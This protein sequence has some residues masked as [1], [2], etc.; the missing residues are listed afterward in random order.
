[1]ESNALLNLRQADWHSRLGLSQKILTAFG[2]LCL[3]WV[4]LLPASP[5]LLKTPGI[6][7]GI[8]LYMGK[9]I[10][11]G[12]IPYRDLWDSNAP[13]VYFFNAIGLFF[14]RDNFWG[15]WVIQVFALWVTALIV[16]ALLKK[17]FGL[18]PA[19][20]I[21]AAVLFGYVYLYDFGNYPEGY[22]LPIQV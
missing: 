16:F 1:M 15:V 12:S 6:N 8:F 22:A 13:L 3:S 9:Q 2:W 11:S 21:T 18:V 17:Y 4:V 5:L 7:F 20:C 10:L 19:A 14:N